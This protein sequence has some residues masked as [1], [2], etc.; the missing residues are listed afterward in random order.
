[1]LRSI[2]FLTAAAL[3][4]Q[5]YPKLSSLIPRTDSYADFVAMA[6]RVGGDENQG[7]VELDVNPYES[8]L[9][10]HRDAA[11]FLFLKAYRSVFPD[12]RTCEI[13]GYVINPVTVAYRM[14]EFDL[15]RSLLDFDKG[16]VNV[17]DEGLQ[18]SGIVPIAAAVEKNDLPW[19]TYFLGKGA[20][21]HTTRVISTKG[22]T[23][24][25]GLNLLSISPS[26]EM[27]KLLLDRGIETVYSFTAPLGGHSLDDGVRIRTDP[28][29]SGSII[30]TM[31]KGEAFTAVG[32]TYKRS[33]INGTS[34]SWIKIMHDGKPGWV[35][36]EFVSI[37]GF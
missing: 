33:L 26:P 28:S 2:T 19:T 34:G 11:V 36:E 22:D 7:T 37:D 27:D 3:G 29:T 10:E 6:Q 23:G 4:A 25:F 30:T 8:L 17:A 5:D 15:V 14:K 13:A 18:S 20:D 32:N 12:D 16:L 9:G 35:F 1:L 31:K 21:V 24:P